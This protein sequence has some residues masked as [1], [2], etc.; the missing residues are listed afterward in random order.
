[1]GVP[2]KKVIQWVKCILSFRGFLPIELK[3]MWVP[4]FWEERS[5]SFRGKKKYSEVKA[6]PLD[7]LK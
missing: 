1:M 4:H 2:L 7:S 5:D 6:Q 3:L